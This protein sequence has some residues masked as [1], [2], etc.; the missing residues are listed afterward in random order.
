M[1]ITVIIPTLNES[2]TIGR[3]IDR[4]LTPNQGQIEIIVVDGG[5]TDD[6]VSIVQSYNIKVLNTSASRA[7]QMNL[8]AQEAKYEILYFVHAD[9]LPPKEY[10]EDCQNY[11]TGDT[12]AA[13]YRSQFEGNKPFLKLNAYFTRF[14]WLV[15]RGGDQ[16]LFIRKADFMTLGM[17]NEDM[18]IMEEYPLIH[19]L[20][21]NR[22]LAI[23]PKQ[24][25]ISCRKYNSRT[26]LR[27][28]R[29]NY[30]AYRLFKKGFPTPVI[31]KRYN[32]LLGD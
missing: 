23:I 4:L 9:T 13:C 18:V 10:I 27:V 32:E 28:N 2:S 15:S 5:S 21:Q 31:Q 11:L 25:C 3:L 22:K 29:A 14:Y 7:K 6:T 19:Q 16:S 1:N 20:M 26:W 30:I 24:I 17:F 12:I 8:G